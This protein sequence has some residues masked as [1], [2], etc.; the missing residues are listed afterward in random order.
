MIYAGYRVPS[1]YDS[2]IAKVI[3]HGAD[4]M[5]AL[6]RMRRALREM[7]VEGIRTNIPFHLRLLEH[8]KF[9]AGDFSTAFL[10][11]ETV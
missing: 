9:I 8:P 6:V 4:R 10:Q 3:T 5:E 1:L 7:K 2:M 11:N